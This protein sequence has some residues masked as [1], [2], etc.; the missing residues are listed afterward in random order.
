MDFLSID[1]VTNSLQFLSAI[2]K[3]QQINS[4][5]VANAHTPGYTAKKVELSNLIGQERNPFETALSKAMGLTSTQID[6]GKPV[7]LK[8]E[9]IAIQENS[10]HYSLATRRL[11]TIFTVLKSAGQVG[12]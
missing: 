8:K 3:Q 10:L 1:G 9:M 11:T 2:S 6:T 12:R 7:D 5:N 4:A